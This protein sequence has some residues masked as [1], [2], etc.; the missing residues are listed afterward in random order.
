MCYNCQCSNYESDEG[1]SDCYDVQLTYPLPPCS[2]DIVTITRHD[3]SRLRPEQYL[4]DNII[5]YYFKRLM[6][7]EYRAPQFIQENVLFLSSHFYS[8]L[9]MG[10]GSTVAERLKAG[11]KNVSTWVTRTDFFSRS[12]IFIPINKDFLQLEWESSHPSAT[13]DD[14]NGEEPSTSPPGSSYDVNKI[15]SISVKAPRQEN[16]YDCGV[17]VLKFAE[18]MLENYLYAGASFGD[19][20]PI[21]N[22]IIKGKLDMLITPT[23]FGAQDITQARINIQK[24]IA[25]DVV[26]YQQALAEQKLQ[27]KQSAAPTDLSAAAATEVEAARMPS[28]MEEDAPLT[29]MNDAR[30]GEPE[31][32]EDHADQSVEKEEEMKES[33]GES[34]E[35]SVQAT[36]K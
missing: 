13:H 23:S 15:V 34:G 8:R 9:C 3:I 18:V 22:E 32:D 10:K 31:A 12:M 19:S 21:D 16:S 2:S 29:M 25:D 14:A 30:D 24:C 17:Y 11:Y 27:K 5:D 7:D 28:S 35:G 4:N 36:I 33:E 6:V 1:G 20:G 26:R